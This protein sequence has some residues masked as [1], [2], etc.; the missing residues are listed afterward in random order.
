MTKRYRV[1]TPGQGT[2]F[3]RSIRFHLD[4][5]DKIQDHSSG[6]RALRFML[7]TRLLR[8]KDVAEFLGVT[9]GRVSQFYIGAEPTPTATRKRILPLLE[10]FVDALKM[11]RDNDE[12]AGDQDWL[13][14]AL[15]D[16]WISIGERLI[17]EERAELQAPAA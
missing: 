16:S 12:F 15:R 8:T 10:E 6:S 3:S 5:F 1:P 14:D 11:N 2:G 4:V 17:E 9:A 7:T 13:T